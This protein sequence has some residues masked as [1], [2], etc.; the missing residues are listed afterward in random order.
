MITEGRWDGAGGNLYDRAETTDTDTTVAT[1]GQVDAY[2]QN[3]MLADAG[4]ERGV[5]RVRQSSSGWSFN[6]K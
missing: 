1:E 3:R 4:P 2:S 6:R 5:A